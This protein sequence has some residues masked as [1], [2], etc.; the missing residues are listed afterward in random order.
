MSVLGITFAHGF[1]YLVGTGAG[2][3]VHDLLKETRSILMPTN[4][5]MSSAMG[6]VSHTPVMLLSI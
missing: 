2:E 5:V 6:T 3:S 1:C 4:V